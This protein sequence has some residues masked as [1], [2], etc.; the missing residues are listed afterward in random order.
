MKGTIFDSPPSFNLRTLAVLGLSTKIIFSNVSLNASYV[1]KNC[2]VIAY[3]YDAATSSTTRYEV[4]QAEM[5]K[6]KE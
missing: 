3:I 4:F 2:Q 1:A 6:V 5:K